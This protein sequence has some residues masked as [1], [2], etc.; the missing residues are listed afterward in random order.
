MRTI[1]V[2]HYPVT[3]FSSFLSTVFQRTK[4]F[5]GHLVHEFTCL[6]SVPTTEIVNS[7]WAREME[8]LALLE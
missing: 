4:A 3:C 2:T 7:K 5:C 8:V 1:L 6:L